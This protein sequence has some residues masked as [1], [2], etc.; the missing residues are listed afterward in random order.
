MRTSPILNDDV[1]CEGYLLEDPNEG[2]VP[3]GNGEPIS[4]SEK[5][6]TYVGDIICYLGD[7]IDSSAYVSNTD[8]KTVA[9]QAC[10]TALQAAATNG[11]WGTLTKTFT[12]Y[13]TSKF[14]SAP[15]IT[16][17]VKFL[18]STW[19]KIG[20]NLDSIGQDL[21]TKGI[22][23][24]LNDPDCTTQ[25]K[26]AGKVQHVSVNGGMIHWTKD[27]KA[28]AWIGDNEFTNCVLDVILEAAN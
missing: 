27:G 3:R 28:S 14:A 8:V 25:R 18:L 13:Y 24:F 17:G 15:V 26:F 22:D 12:G 5:D 21:C 20:S 23:H 4:A 7:K 10:N 9:V 6:Q 19:P 11:P 2:L 1:C 16:P